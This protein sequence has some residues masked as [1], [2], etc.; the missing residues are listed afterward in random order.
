[1]HHSWPVRLTRTSG[2]AR[3][4]SDW[5][6]DPVCRVIAGVPHDVRFQTKPEIAL[7][8]MRQ[9]LANGVWPA[10][11]LMDATTMVWRLAKH[12]CLLHPRSGRSQPAK[13]LRRDGT[14]RPVA[15][16]A[17][18]LELAADAWQTITWR[19]GRDTPQ[20]SRF[21]GWSA[22]ATVKAA[23][24]TT[25][26]TLCIAAYGSLIS[27]KETISPSGQRHMHSPSPGCAYVSHTRRFPP[28][29]D[30]RVAAA[31]VRHWLSKMSDAVGLGPVV[32]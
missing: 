6:D 11:A 20:T 10:V 3:A 1:V 31:R 16:K 14:H 12:R 9:A 15:A 18:A 27:E 21:A 5:A 26:Q 4:D 13:L 30:V 25:T 17:L 22:S 19:D 28:C 29:H 32:N 8:Q 2:T 7:Q 23:A 24:F